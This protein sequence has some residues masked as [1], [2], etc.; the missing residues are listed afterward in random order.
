MDKRTL[1]FVLSLTLTLFLVNL[2][3]ENRKADDLRVWSQQQS[4]K[5]EETVKKLSEEISNRTASP[6]SLPLVMLYADAE[7]KDKLAVGVQSEKAV[8]AIAWNKTIPQKIYKKTLNG[9][10][11]L[12]E[13]S[14]ASSNLEQ[15]NL[16]IYRENNKES[17]VVG[18][19]PE[20]GKYEIQIVVPTVNEEGPSYQIFLG[21][22]TDGSLTIPALKISSLKQEIGSEKKIEASTIGEGIA[23]AKRGDNYI[24][25]ALY[26]HIQ[27]LLEPLDALSSISSLVSKPREKEKVASGQKASEKFY[28]LETPYQQLVFSSYGGA[29]VEI[30]LPFQSNNDEESVVKEIQF[31]R[32]MVSKHPYN[33]HFP[34][35]AYSTPGNGENG[36]FVEHT[37]GVLG[38]YYP[39]LR[40]DLIQTI[41]ANLFVYN[42]VTML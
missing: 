32:D 20:F 31:D 25:V 7:G 22:Y 4:A 12:V 26:D 40:R 3:F 27:K 34:A 35:H 6:A 28:V 33:A 24:P 30:N 14:L 42:L 29:L 36:P 10:D 39:L 38:G 21:D 15:G 1:L 19:L 41:N 23:L 11:K 18:D 9:D 17:L 2:F 16:V 37:A 8:L 13:L 5:K